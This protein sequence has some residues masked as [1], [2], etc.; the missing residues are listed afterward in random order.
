[1]PFN[2]NA[3]PGDLAGML[4]NMAANMQQGQSSQN[5]QEDDGNTGGTDEPGIRLGGNINLNFGENMPEEVTGALRSM[6]EMFSGASDPG[7]PQDTDTTHG[8]TSTS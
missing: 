6:M 4:M 3:L 1:M 5:R 2:A 7:N 8:R